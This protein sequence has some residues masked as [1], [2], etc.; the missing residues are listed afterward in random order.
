MGATCD[1][2]DLGSINALRQEVLRRG[3][4]EGEGCRHPDRAPRPA[5]STF[6]TR[7]V[8]ACRAV[9]TSSSSETWLRRAATA[10]TIGDVFD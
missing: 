5:V 8:S 6:P 3:K 10:Q 1:C 9:T 2:Y 7:Y 4:A